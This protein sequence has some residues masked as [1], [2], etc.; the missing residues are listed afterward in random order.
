MK[1][2]IKEKRPPPPLSG[3]V[4]I[5]L[6]AMVVLAVLWLQSVQLIVSCGGLG[7]YMELRALYKLANCLPPAVIGL[8][9]FAATRRWGLTLGLGSVL[10]FLWSAANH[11]T[12]LFSG[13]AI[14]VSILSSLGTAMNV[15]GGYRFAPDG[16]IGLILAALAL[17]LLLALLARRLAPEPAPGKWA[18]PVSAGLAGA[19]VAV[20]A[21]CAR[22]ELSFHWNV[23]DDAQRYGYGFYFVREATF[24][25]EK[26]REPA[27]YGD[28]D[29]A[30]LLE[31]YPGVPGTDTEYPDIILI[32]NE[33]FYD[34]ERYTDMM[35]DAPVMESWYAIDNAVRGFVATGEGTNTTEYELLTGNSVNLLSSR[36][37]FMDLDLTGGNS[38]ARYLK[39]L[40]YET[41]A[42]HEATPSNY[43]RGVGY[44]AL[45]FDQVKFEGDF[46]YTTAYGK[47][48]STDAANYMDLLDW[49]VSAQEGP[50]FLYLLTYQN[51]AG[52]DQND[53]RFDTVHT[54]RDFGYDTDDMEEYLTSV[55]MSCEAFSALLAYLDESE[56]PVLVC[57]LG[58]HAPYLT[59]SASPYPNLSREETEAI[60][61]T[62]P[63]LLWANAAF[64]HLE[65][66]EDVDLT[67]TDVIPLIAR[68]AGLPLSPYYQCIL[69]TAETIPFRLQDGAYRSAEGAYGVFELG[70]SR[71]EVLAPYYWM[72]YG[73]LREMD[74]WRGFFDIPQAFN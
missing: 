50:R 15:L 52:Y 59:D 22:T 63:F 34:M 18:W 36:A 20:C 28:A 25:G 60:L 53:S 9:L 33:S 13:S 58:D 46:S 35:L 6:C 71:Y 69:E 54:A 24:F 14:T 8:I 47:R 3:R 72:E 55:R 4:R 19:L 67:A 66:A 51:H 65:P 5:P 43:G 70:D 21:L 17:E 68:T 57:M 10:V 2:N 42:M 40:G 23:G 31:R 7:T 41:W 37:P 45:G 64:G 26:V 32:L 30:E 74:R 27:G 62:T 48:K 39:A 61:Q 11:Y 12:Y 73:A 29:P 38:A 56:R 16:D 49:Y 44:P 1:G